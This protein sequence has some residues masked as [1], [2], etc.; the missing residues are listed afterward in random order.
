MDL[1]DEFNFEPRDNMASDYIKPKDDPI[2]FLDDNDNSN[3]TALKSQS[4]PLPSFLDSLSNNPQPSSGVS[5][6]LY[7]D[8]PN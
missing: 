5:D 7:N 2:N 1:S 6:L 8:E 3:T 4:N